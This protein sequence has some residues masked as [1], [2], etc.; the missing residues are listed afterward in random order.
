MSKNISIIILFIITLSFINCEEKKKDNTGAAAAAY[1]LTR[2]STSGACASG[3]TTAISNSTL[4]GTTATATQ[5]SISGCDSN[6]L[7][8]LGLSSQNITTGVTGTS[9]NSK[10]AANGDLFSASDVNIEVTFKLDN[11]SGYLEVIGQGSGTASSID[12]PA[13]RINSSSTQARGTG[14]S[15]LS[16]LTSQ[17]TTTG[18]TV[19]YCLEFHNESP[20][21]H[22]VF[23]PTACTSVS[24]ADKSNYSGREATVT[25]SFPGKRIGFILNNATLTSFTVR[26]KIGIA[27]N[28]LQ[29]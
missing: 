3:S 13:I 17:T 14:S 24:T 9:A 7:S 2:G 5:Y 6:S 15:T 11:A 1:L 26:T 29:P 10:I 20:S 21:L 12:G 25:S 27:T 22:A 4:S 18:Q 23:W 16:N 8:S 19:T 28:L